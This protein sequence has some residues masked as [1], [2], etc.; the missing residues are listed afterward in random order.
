MTRIIN[1]WNFPEALP[2]AFN[3]NLDAFSQ[4][5]RSILAKM[6]SWILLPMPGYTGNAGS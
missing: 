3:K 4:P 2:A 5:F 6:I 1:R